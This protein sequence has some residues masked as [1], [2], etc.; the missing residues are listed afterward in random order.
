[1]EAPVLGRSA[2]S[3]RIPVSIV[4]GFLGSGK[5]TLVN[6]L[7]KRPDM[8]KVA[9]IVNE[10][11]EQAI[12]N[13]LV[14]VS[15]EQMMLLNNGCLC[16]V[17]R[18]DLQETLRDLFVKRRNGEIIDFDRVVIETTG[19]AD[20]APVMQA[21]SND[22]ALTEL[23]R[24]DGVITLVDGAQGSTQLTHTVEAVKQAAVADRIVITKS[25]LT[26]EA[27]IA[28]LEA[29]LKAINPT[30]R[31]TRAVKG[32]VEPDLLL[33]VGIDRARVAPEVVDRWLGPAEDDHDHHGDHDHDLSR[34]GGVGQSGGDAERDR[35]RRLPR[36]DGLPRHPGLPTVRPLP[37]GGERMSAPAESSVPAP[38][39]GTS[40]ARVRRMTRS[41][42]VGMVMWLVLFLVLAAGPFTF[43]T[44][45]N[46]QNLVTLFIYIIL[47]T[48]WNL[49][50]GFAGVVSVGQQAFVGL[51]AYSMVALINVQ[52]QNLYISIPL[53]ALLTAIISIPIAF[54]AFRLRGSYFA[55]G[56]WVIA[57]VIKLLTLI[58]LITTPAIIVGTW[59]GM[60]FKVM[61]ELEWRWGYPAVLLFMALLAA[62]MVIYFRRKKWLGGKAGRGSGRG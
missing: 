43:L 41:S 46:Q 19:L 23:Y 4:T 18:G 20:P 36:H 16:C 12:D 58:T 37:E 10:L 21:I 30:G 51:G 26:D 8:N 15:S 40:S 39:A 42:Y 59:Y 34:A 24:L 33:S 9:V 1:M 57:E 50:A 44:K 5:T 29:E 48:M 38:Q 45:G 25:D 49:L 32:V 22:A 7:L 13:D 54:I 35:L 2:L 17:L 60:N 61:P 47:G 27:T 55:I 28:K 11:G 14:E 31:I 52:G 3:G 53:S 56:T 6:K 62:G